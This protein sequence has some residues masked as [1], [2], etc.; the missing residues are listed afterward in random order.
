MNSKEIRRLFFEYFT[1]HQHQ[2]VLSAPLVP[3]QDPTL[4]FTNAGMNQFKGV[5]L[6]QEKRNYNRAVTIQKC[7]RVS[8]KHNDFDEVGKTPF[9]HTFSK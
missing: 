6:Q 5:F 9:H 3:A 7:M 2:R 4:L 8:G 1:R